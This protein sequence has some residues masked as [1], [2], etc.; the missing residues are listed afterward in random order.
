MPPRRTTRQS[1]SNVGADVG[2]A[3][4]PVAPPVPAARPARRAAA[5]RVAAAPESDGEEASGAGVLLGRSMNGREEDEDDL[6]GNPAPA[7][8]GRAT[9]TSTSTVTSASASTSSTTENAPGKKQPAKAASQSKPA[10]ATLAPAPAPVRR[11][12][13]LSISSEASDTLDAPA[14]PSPPARKPARALKARRKAAVVNSDSEDDDDNAKAEE[15]LAEDDSG[16]MPAEVVN[17]AQRPLLTPSISGSEGRAGSVDAGTDSGSG[18]GLNSGS[19]SDATKEAVPVL[20][21]KQSKAAAKV[22][23]DS[24]EDEDAGDVTV[25][26]DDDTASLTATP[27]KPSRRAVWPA[28]SARAGPSHVVA[29]DPAKKEGPKPRLVIHKLVL[30]NFKSYQ[31]RQEIGPFHKVRLASTSPHEL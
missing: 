3:P 18:S 26:L 29:L 8:K 15:A 16:E 22:E 5:K 2:A 14:P 12:A 6:S 4:V 19:E 7:R 11:S 1:A 25:R 20:P 17:L 30:V 23:S 21:A 9:R 24:D 31:G 13:R 27:T 10:A 28:V